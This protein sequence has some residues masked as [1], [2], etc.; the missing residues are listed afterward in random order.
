MNMS[1]VIYIAGKMRGLIDCGREH[2]RQAEVFLK[3]M[4]Y[5]VMN[6]ARLP[7]NM[8]AESYMP[9]C[10]AMLREADAIAMLP[11]WEDSIGAKMEHQFAVETEKLIY[12]MKDDFGFDYDSDESPDSDTKLMEDVMT[13]TKEIVKEQLADYLADQLAEDL[14]EG[15][16]EGMIANDHL[17]I[18][19]FREWRDGMK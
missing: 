12:M 19:H 7:E 3:K 8:P 6:P 10:L 15:I 18:K 13:L 9:I 2:F 17:Y 5:T 11:D 14:T 1:D 4:G 16:A